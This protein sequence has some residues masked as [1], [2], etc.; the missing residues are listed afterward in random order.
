MFATAEEKH[1]DIKFLNQ[2]ERYWF[3]IQFYMNLNVIKIKVYSSLVHLVLLF[4]LNIL[5]NNIFNNLARLILLIV[6]INFII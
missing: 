2:C 4:A 6:S 3:A 5:K 1:I